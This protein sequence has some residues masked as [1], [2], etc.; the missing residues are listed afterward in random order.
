MKRTYWMLAASLC[1]M[2]IGGFAL[3]VSAQQTPPPAAAPSAPPSTT[4]PDS[5]SPKPATPPSDSTMQRENPA[6]PPSTN[7]QTDTR[8]T[9]RNTTVV[10]REG[11]R[12]FGVQPTVALVIGAALLVVIVFGLVAMSRRSDDVTHTHRV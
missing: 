8:T 1:L 6:N 12:I 4:P 5:T 3:D 11:G 10:D 9:E 2:L 7:T